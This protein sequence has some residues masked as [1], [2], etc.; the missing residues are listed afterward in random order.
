VK[1]VRGLEYG[2]ELVFTDVPTPTTEPTSIVYDR[3]RLTQLMLSRRSGSLASR[4]LRDIGARCLV[5][6]TFPDQLLEQ[7]LAG[8]HIYV[9]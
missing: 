3:E 2:G 7:H 1:A 8:R 5:E 6:K 4:R 9:P